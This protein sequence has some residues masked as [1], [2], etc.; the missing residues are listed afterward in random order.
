[1]VTMPRIG[2]ALT[3]S[4][5]VVLASATA[6][7]QAPASAA[8]A[9]PKAA[10][11]SSQVVATVGDQP[12]TADDADARVKARLFKARQAE[13][14]AQVDGIR[15]AAF[16]MLQEREATKL[17]ITREA[18][19]RKEVTDKVVQ[20]SDAE[21]QQIF[22][23]YR[24]RLP[25]DDDA[26]KTEVR[27]VLLNRNTT[28]RVEAF[29]AELFGG[30]KLRI[31]VDPPR[32][33]VPAAAS[34]PSLGPATAGVTLVEFSDF[35][36]PYC[37]RAQTTIKQLR[38]EYS[39]R[40]RFVFRQLPLGMHPQAHLAAEAALCA[41]DQGKYWEAREWMFSHQGG[42]TA[43]ALKAWAKD[44][45]LDAGAFATC[46]DSDAHAKEIDA[47]MQ[48]AEALGTA[49]TPTFFV[50]GRLIEG[51]YPIEQFRSVIDDELARV[52][53]PAPTSSR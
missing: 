14:D 47:D 15:E 41:S 19:Y 13:Y 52:K 3:L 1:M 53:P 22:T 11:A 42:V 16:E 8:T 27:R 21:V 40:V 10:A 24:T 29:K 26:A 6:G 34:S 32:L 39:D 23:T 5:G 30:A 44:A 31:L 25:K 50:N 48:T 2:A 20:P 9:P 28:Q 51:A 35:Q 36:C 38:S 43:D 49:S 46:L 12:I 33:D 37:Q 18:Y 17:G 4:W 45:G 7:A